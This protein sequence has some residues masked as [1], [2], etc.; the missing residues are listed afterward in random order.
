MAER[1]R[2]EIEKE[3]GLVPAGF[4]AEMGGAVY[5]L[6]DDTEH[7]VEI[8]VPAGGAS[9]VVLAGKCDARTLR[10]SMPKTE[11]KRA[12]LL[13]TDLAVLAD[14][15]D[16]LDCSVEV[17]VAADEVLIAEL[18][19]KVYVDS[20]CEITRQQIAM[21]MAFEEAQITDFYWDPRL[22]F[23]LITLADPLFHFSGT[24]V[25][26]LETLI[27][28]Y[29]LSSAPLADII[30]EPDSVRVVYIVSGPQSVTPLVIGSDIYLEDLTVRR[31]RPKQLKEASASWYVPK[32][33]KE[34]TV[35]LTDERFDKDGF[36][37]G[38]TVR[39]LKL[40]G[41][42]LLEEEEMNYVQLIINWMV[43]GGPMK[44]KVAEEE[45][46]ICLQY[47]KVTTYAYDPMPN[48]LNVHY[49]RNFKLIERDENTTYYLPTS[50]ENVIEW[51]TDQV[52][53]SYSYT[54]EGKLS[55]EIQR[56]A[57]DRAAYG[58]EGFVQG[59][60]TEIT[61]FLI[62]EDMYQLSKNISSF[63]AY[64]VSEDEVWPKP[65]DLSPLS[66][67]TQT[68]MGD[69]PSPPS[70]PLPKNEDYVEN[71]ERKEELDVHGSIAHMSLSFDPLGVFDVF[72]DRVTSAAVRVS[73][74]GRCLY[75][76]RPGL[77]IHLSIAKDITV[78]TRSPSGSVEVTKF[79]ELLDTLPD[80]FVKSVTVELEDKEQITSIEALGWIPTRALP[81]AAI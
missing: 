22:N 13:K 42:V 43:T 3:V 27:A 37:I 75:D 77:W 26:L 35:T 16:K 20:S 24:F 17:V 1:T 40:I 67:I 47:K 38:R 33:L 15:Q 72:L 19:G 59:E 25:D 55:R 60:I 29:K 56:T 44:I 68:V 74:S 53:S 21:D 28:P 5:L 11:E 39:V 12:G 14:I 2:E 9:P 73:M 57:K 71:K 7:V 54:E 62:S 18:P 79:S 32:E 50:A 10:I 69:L 78:T 8:N 51:H 61:Y 30:I 52:L 66:H 80:L 70:I 48:D 58:E 76:L 65:G 6:P 81:E 23:P 4:I 34:E 64:D 31:S 36:V 49:I 45:P 41:N 63:R 46:L